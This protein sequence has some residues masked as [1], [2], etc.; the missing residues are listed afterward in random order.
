MLQLC[1]NLG[2]LLGLVAQ[3]DRPQTVLPT[4]SQSPVAM[5]GDSGELQCR[6]RRAA[7]SNLVNRNYDLLAVLAEFTGNGSIA[8]TASTFTK[9]T[10]SVNVGGGTDGSQSTSASLTGSVT[11]TYTP[12]PEPSTLTL[13]ALGT[14]GLALIRLRR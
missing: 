4:K 6:E 7:I 9:V 12:A 8:L 1:S 3:V 14:V 10:V 5:T 13:L 2:D 11:Y